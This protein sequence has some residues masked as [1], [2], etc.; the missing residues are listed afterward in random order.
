MIL[1]D[2]RIPAKM[3]AETLEISRERVGYIIHEILYMRKLSAK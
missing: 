1:D 3:I 2:R